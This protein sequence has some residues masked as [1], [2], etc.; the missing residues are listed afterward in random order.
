MIVKHVEYLYR[1]TK[2]IVSGMVKD[3]LDMSG[4]LWRTCFYKQI[5]EFRSAI[6]KHSHNLD[7]L[8]NSSNSD[9]IV[10]QKQ[11]LHVARLTKAFLEFLSDSIDFFQKITTEVSG[12]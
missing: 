9:A 3:R 10:V 8:M 7:K 11:Q 2:D 5:T 1:E 6:K 4:H 12:I